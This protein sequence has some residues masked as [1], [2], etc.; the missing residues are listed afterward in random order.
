MLKVNYN[1]M[2]GQYSADGAYATVITESANE[3]YKL[4]Y[5]IENNFA[6]NKNNNTI[7]CTIE[8]D[9]EIFSTTQEFTF[10]QSGSNGSDY[11]LVLDLLTSDNMITL[12]P[13]NNLIGFRPIDQEQE[14]YNSTKDYYYI[15]NNLF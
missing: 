15:Y 11:T 8:K 1:M 9:G 6:F 7:T 14:T 5:T 3:E 4:Y 12:N 10:G 13:I 2:N